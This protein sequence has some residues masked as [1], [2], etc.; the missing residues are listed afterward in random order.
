MTPK[1][2]TSEERM[3]THGLDRGSAA[4]LGNTGSA[5]GAET[6]FILMSLHIK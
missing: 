3:S 4:D 6:S 5:N 1:Y 2:P